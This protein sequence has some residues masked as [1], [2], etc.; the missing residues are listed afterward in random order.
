MM[1]RLLREH[2]RI[3]AIA[4]AFMSVPVLV[5]PGACIVGCEGDI[6]EPTVSV[7]VQDAGADA[8]SAVATPSA[9]KGISEDCTKNDECT[10]GVCFAGNKSS[11]CTLACTAANATQVCVGGTFNGVCNMQGYCRRP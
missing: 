1:R 11:Y 3:D 5:A 8:D 6:G 10:S 9:K 4:F 2:E 7:I